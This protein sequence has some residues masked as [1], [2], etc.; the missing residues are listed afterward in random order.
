MEVVEN[1]GDL[2]HLGY[3]ELL[4]EPAFCSVLDGNGEVVAADVVHENGV[5]AARLVGVVENVEDAGDSWVIERLH[6]ARFALEA[7]DSDFATA[8]RVGDGGCDLFED[9]ELAVLRVGNSIHLAECAV[10]EYGADDVAVPFAE[11]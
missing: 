11:G 5:L 10:V 4:A 9:D 8:F 1:G 6:E 7:I 2:H 3:E